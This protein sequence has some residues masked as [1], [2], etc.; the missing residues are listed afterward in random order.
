VFARACGSQHTLPPSGVRTDNH[1]K[2]R[3]WATVGEEPEPEVARVCEV[4]HSCCAHGTVC[5]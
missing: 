5:K 1:L 2:V 3:F 4:T